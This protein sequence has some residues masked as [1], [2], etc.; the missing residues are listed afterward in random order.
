VD[1]WLVIALI[2]VVVAVGLAVL[3]FAGLRFAAALKRLLTATGRTGA[4][5]ADETGL[6]RARRAALRVAVAQRK[7]RNTDSTR[8]QVRSPRG[9]QEKDLIG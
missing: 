7:A 1:T 9:R 8:P 4:R 3:V 2:A 5:F 6:L